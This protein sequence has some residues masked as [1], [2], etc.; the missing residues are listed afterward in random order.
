MSAPT[1][2]GNIGPNGLIP[3][4]GSDE[5]A[6]SIRTDG[7]VPQPALT[8]RVIVAIG[9]YTDL[10]SGNW[11]YVVTDVPVTTTW[12][13][14]KNNPRL[15]LPYADLMTQDEADANLPPGGVMPR[16]NRIM[17][18]IQS[19]AGVAQQGLSTSF[20]MEGNP[21]NTPNPDTSLNRI[22]QEAS[23][24]PYPSTGFITGPLMEP[25]GGMTVN[26]PKVPPAYR[27]GEITV[28]LQVNGYWPGT[29]S[30]RRGYHVLTGEQASSTTVVRVPIPQSLLEGFAVS[31][32]GD[33]GQT[34]FDY[35]VQGPSDAAWGQYPHGY[36]MST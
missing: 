35:S 13:A 21:L 33:I 17:W 34:Y 16:R 15:L 7:V 11:E 1:I 14:I 20:N 6:I 10:I 19:A 25:N 29:I 4:P 24:N 5:L 28:Y 22:L 36:K 2:M 26:I 32:N 12:G 8:D 31:T 30:P 9:W 23:I 27:G 3:D 18:F